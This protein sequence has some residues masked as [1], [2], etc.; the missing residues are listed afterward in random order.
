MTVYL[1]FAELHAMH[2]KPLTMHD[3]IAKLDKFLALGDRGI[4]GHVGMAKPDAAKANAETEYD[5]MA[6][7]MSSN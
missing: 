5:N 7:G 6:N 1:E 4:L 3:W 2:P